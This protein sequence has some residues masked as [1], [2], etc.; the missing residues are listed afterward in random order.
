MHW[1]LPDLDHQ[2][3]RGTLLASNQPGSAFWT[4]RLLLSA[5][6]IWT[7]NP[8]LTSTMSFQAGR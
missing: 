4:Q 3:W 6:V 1:L 2:T 7:V 5:G 8:L